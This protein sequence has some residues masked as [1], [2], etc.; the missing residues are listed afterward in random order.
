MGSAALGIS[1][2]EYICKGRGIGFLFLFFF[3]L[4]FF[5]KGRGLCDVR[6][7]YS[8]GGKCIIDLSGTPPFF[9]CI[10]A[11]ERREGKK[12]NVAGL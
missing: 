6:G 10:G 9:F 7:L 3:F 11:G 12:M 5:A 8:L 4:F 1:A 2:W